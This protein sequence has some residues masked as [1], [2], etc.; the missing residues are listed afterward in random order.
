MKKSI[1]IILALFAILFAGCA[2]AVKRAEEI[3]ERGVLRVGV[4]SDVLS[5]GYLNPAT[6]EYEGIEIEIARDMAKALTGDENAVQFIPVTALTRDML[7]ANR[8]VDIIIATFTITEERKKSYNFSDPYY[9]DEIGFLVR[10]DSGISVF[11]DIGGKTVGVTHSSTANTGL[12]GDVLGVDY[13]LKSFASYPEIKNALKTGAVDVFAADKSILFGYLDGETVLLEKGIL[14]QPYG[15]ATTLEDKAFSK[16][17]ND[18][19][20][21]MKSGGTL[22]AILEKWSLKKA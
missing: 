3:K 18:H 5:F 11:E 6:G 22:D 12:S 16:F 20:Q 1:V 4:K 13:T 8:E 21:K 9:T 19:L 17:I 10:A 15:I 2:P 7:L 14:P